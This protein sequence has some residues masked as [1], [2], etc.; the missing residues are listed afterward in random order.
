MEMLLTFFLSKPMFHSATGILPSSNYMIFLVE[1]LLFSKCRFA[2]KGNKVHVV[3]DVIL[4]VHR[5]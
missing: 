3:F 1:R 4:T 5:R 2:A